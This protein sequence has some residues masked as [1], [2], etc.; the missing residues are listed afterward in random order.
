[1]AISFDLAVNAIIAGLLLGGFYAAVT[2]GVTIS[3]GMLDIVNIAHPAFI[4]LGS[5]V[6]YTINSSFG[7]D[8]VLIGVAMAPLFFLLGMAVYQILLLC[9][10]APRRR[11]DPGPR[12]FLWPV[13]CWRGGADSDL[14]CRLPLC[15][16]ALYRPEPAFRL[17]R[18]AVAH[19]DPV[20]RVLANGRSCCKGFSGAAL[21]GG[22]SS[23]CRR[24]G[25]R[26]S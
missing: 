9:L 12:L 24:I 25:W 13:V 11:I 1:M 21:S 23:P 4:M 3:F 22:P 16:G 8:P 10:R 7:L 2:V 20:C 26:C 19:A 6:A 18:A 14:R 17:S 15:R 5:F